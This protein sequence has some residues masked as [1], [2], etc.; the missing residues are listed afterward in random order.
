MAELGKW[1][2]VSEAARLTGISVRTLKR[3]AAEGQLKHSR[4]P[5]GHMRVLRKDLEKLLR[6]DGPVTASLSIGLQ[7]KREAVEAKGLELQE[8]RADRELRKLREEDAEAERRRAATAQA[9]EL[10]RR[11]AVEETRLQVARHAAE[12]WARE[13]EQEEAEERREW[14]DRWVAWALN[15]VPKDAPREVALD[16]H[17]GVEEALAKLSPEQSQ[18]VVQRLVLAAMDRGLAPW[19]RRKEIENAVQLARKEVPLVVRTLSE[20]FP[21]TQWEIRAMQSAREAIAELPA[22]ASYEELRAAAVQAGKQI[23]TEYEGE[24]ARARAEGE[25]QQRERS[26]KFRV[27]IGVDH[28]SVYLTKLHSAG[29]LWDEDL[30]RKPE[31]EAA[32]RKVLGEKLTGDESFDDTQRLARKVIDAELE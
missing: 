14:T 27:D 5:G 30:S 3:M 2:S 23:A 12:R 20:Y 13:R 15:A 16:V 29:E 10:E 8:A 18:S 19:N 11:R 21:P 17:Q 9:E 1:V 32:V 26:K 6:Q 22:D 25:R 24:Q 31:L 7:S 28:V 4:T